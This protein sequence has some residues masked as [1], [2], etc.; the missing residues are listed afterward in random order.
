ME[1]IVKKLTDESLMRRACEMTMHGKE[2]KMTLEDMYF[3]EHSPTRTQ[4]YWIEIYG[5]PS[6]VSTHFVRH[7]T[8]VEHFI[9]TNRDDRGGDGAASRW[10]E[11]NHAMAL[12]AQTLI[13]MA[14]KRLCKQAHDAARKVMLAIVEAMKDIDPAL[15]EKLV[16]DCIYRGGCFELRPCGFM[17]RSNAY[18]IF[19]DK[20]EKFFDEIKKN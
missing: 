16:P 17:P 9:M 1:V 18:D 10:A 13:F 11:V 6:F 20:R 14:R 3:C 12:N 7:K 19:K 2:S 15:A 4:E 5:L 8:G